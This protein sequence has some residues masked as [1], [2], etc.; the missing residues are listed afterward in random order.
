LKLWDFGSGKLID[1]VPWSTGLHTTSE[2]CLLYAAQFSK[3]NNAQ[4][5]AA[6]GSGANEVKVFQ[7]DNLKV[8]YYLSTIILKLFKLVGEIYGFKKGVYTLDFSSDSKML[9]VGGAG[10][11]LLYEMPQATPKQTV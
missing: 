6:G 10:M 2:P 5:I 8:I 4:Y 3:N 1:T 7:R 9:T 11:L